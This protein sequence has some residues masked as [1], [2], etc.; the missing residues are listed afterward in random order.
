[1]SKTSGNIEETYYQVLQVPSTISLVE[2][3]KSY[4]A[5]AIKFHPDK[6]P[7]DPV[8]AER[9]K[10]ITEAYAVLSDPSKRADYDRFLQDSQNIDSNDTSSNSGYYESYFDKK[11]D[12]FDAFTDVFS[13]NKNSDGTSNNLDVESTIKV[14]LPDAVYGKVLDLNL[15]IEKQCPHCRGSSSLTKCRRCNNSGFIKSMRKVRTEIPKGIDSGAVLRVKSGGESGGLFAQSGDLFLK[16]EVQPHWLYTRS[17]LDLHLTLP[18][19]FLEATL[20]SDIIIPMLNG[21]AATIKLPQGVSDQK[22]LRI[23][24]EGVELNSGVKGDLLINFTI[25]VPSKLTSKER[26]ILENYRKVSTESNPRA[27]LFNIRTQP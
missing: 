3:K 23:P 14:S 4:H 9:F 10:R 21:S 6:N 8:S 17:N 13:K 24:G 27:H 18:I 11:Q 12:I 1:M 7:G 20:G 2:L 25:T 26:K 19:T 16:I 22:T 5:L 15:E